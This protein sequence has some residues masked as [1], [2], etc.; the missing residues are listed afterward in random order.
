MIEAS[1]YRTVTVSE[2]SSGPV[3]HSVVFNALQSPLDLGSA[4]GAVDGVVMRTGVS[5]QELRWRVSPAQ[6]VAVIYIG[7]CLMDGTKNYQTEMA[8]AVE[9][10]SA[11]DSGTFLG[12]PYVVDPHLPNDTVLLERISAIPVGGIKHLAVPGLYPEQPQEQAPQQ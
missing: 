10:G 5:R 8:K 9:A 6:R 3:S 12:I 11:F 4:M 2:G 7:L 1:E